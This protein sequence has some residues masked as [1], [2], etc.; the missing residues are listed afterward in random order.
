M[1]TNRRYHLRKSAV[2]NL[3]NELSE[4]LGPVVGEVLKG[5]VEVVQLD[6]E[7]EIILSNEKPV[8]LKS[9]K[10]VFPALPS[11]ESFSMKRVIVDMGAVGPVT[12]GANVMSPGVRK[13]D[14]SISIGDTVIIL[15]EKNEKP[16][17]IGK[18]L[19]DGLSMK[20]RH[21]EVVKNL[22]YVGD[23]VWK[24]VSKV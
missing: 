4:S 1:S 18:A 3:I 21:G 19:S 15:D 16:L 12:N 2:K 9:R 11:V 5:K 22:H 14:E 13:A 17:A 23:K 6:G 8:L 24:M 7:I 20:G 10:G